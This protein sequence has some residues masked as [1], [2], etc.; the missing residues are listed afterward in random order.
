MNEKQKR[1]VVMIPR[2][3]IFMAI[4]LYCS[5]L[6]RNQIDLVWFILGSFFLLCLLFF[7][8]ISKLLRK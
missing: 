6:V 3:I 7:F 2:I 4:V 5:G 1:T 8:D